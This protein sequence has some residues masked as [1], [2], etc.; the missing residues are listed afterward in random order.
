MA[1][2]TQSTVLVITMAKP[3]QSTAQVTT[4]AKPTQ[5]TAQ[6]IIMAKQHPPNHKENSDSPSMTFEFK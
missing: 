3:T 1:K 4:I 5:S 6:V 2:P